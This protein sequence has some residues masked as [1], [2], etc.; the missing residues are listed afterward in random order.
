MRKVVVA[1]DVQSDGKG[2]GPYTNTNRIVNSKLQ[3]KYSFE[4]INYDINKGRWISISRIFDLARQIKKIKPD[5]V[6]FTGLQLSAF[7]IIIA[8]KIVGVRNTIMVVRGFTDEMIY[9]SNAK[10]LLAK[11]IFEL[12]TLLLVKKYYTNSIFSQN[13]SI[14]QSFKNKSCG[15]I[16][17]LPPSTSCTN[18]E[19]MERG[20]RTGLGLADK[21]ILVVTIGRI[22]FEKGYHILKDTILKFKGHNIIKFIIIGSGTYLNEMKTQVH[23]NNCSDN[24]YFLGYRSDIINILIECDIFVFPTL[25]ETFGS[26][27]LEAAQVGLPIIASDVGGIPEIVEDGVNGILVKPGDVCYLYNAIKLLSENK[28]LRERLGRGSKKIIESKFRARKIEE[29]ISS[30][31]DVVISK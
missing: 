30:A 16:Y 17:N 29:E 9:Y 2:G 12:T 13:K 23:K 5:I 24:V 25:H 18:N 26:A 6:H 22:N 15:V 7:H 19:F 3:N 1:V 20:F 10:K 31:Y 4:F 27:A 28:V 11:Y 8:C 21:D 14:L